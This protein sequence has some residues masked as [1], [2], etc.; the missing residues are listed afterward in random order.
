MIKVKMAK[1]TLSLAW[2]LVL[3]VGLQ[4]AIR[5]WVHFEASSGLHLVSFPISFTTNCFAILCGTNDSDEVA[6]YNIHTGGYDINGFDYAFSFSINK[7]AR[8]IAIGN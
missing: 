6:N 7:D 2:I 5:K 1:S 8:A 4:C 3:F